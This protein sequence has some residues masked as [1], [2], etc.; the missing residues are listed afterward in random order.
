MRLGSSDLD[1]SRVG[2]GCNN[3][4]RR[5]DLAR[6]RE[7]VDA[8][9]DAGIT[10]FDTADIYGLG[11][12]ERF[13]GEAL[14]T[15]RDRVVVATKFGNDM[16][17]ANGDGPGGSPAYVRRAIEAS[18]ARLRTDYVD[19]YYYHRPDGV[20]PLD[21]TLGAMRRLVDEGKVRWLGLSNVDAAQ[22]AAVA[23]GGSPVVAV[24]NYYSLMWRD[25]DAEVLPLCLEHGIGYVPYFPLESGLLTGKYRRGEPAPA[26]SRLEGVDDERLAAERFDRVEALEAFAVRRGHTLLEL[27]IGGLASIPG[28]ASVIA[29]ATSPEQVRANAAAGDRH[30]SAAE[31]GELAALSGRPSDGA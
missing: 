18:L 12:S 8:A 6:T 15:R 4:G 3:F 20:T 16:Q 21:E 27:A 10:F 17:G 2:L 25:D 22:I 28:V 7:V 14:G 13:L 29:G 24:Q 5:I 31:L 11:D 9:V 1:V 19:L 30:L 23:A 26:G